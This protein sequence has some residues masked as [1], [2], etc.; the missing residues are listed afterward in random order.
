MGVVGVNKDLMHRFQA[1]CAPVSECSNNYKA[2]TR[3]KNRRITV[4]RNIYP[5]IGFPQI[6]NPLYKKQ[7]LIFI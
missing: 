3:K 5:Y 1:P 4:E 6:R 2:F 7:I